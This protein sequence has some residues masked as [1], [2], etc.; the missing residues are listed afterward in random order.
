MVKYVKEDT[1]VV[2][3]EIPDE[4]TLAINISNC[5]NNCVGCHSPYL[6]KDIGDELTYDVIDEL[7]KE[8]DGVTC[9][10]FMGEGNDSDGLLSLARYVRDEKHLK[11]ALYSGRDVLNPNIF[12]NFDYVKT[13]PYMAEFGPL[14]KKTTNQ[15]LY[16]VERES[17]YSIEIKNITE[18]FWKNEN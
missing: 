5:Q 8:N 3:E 11:V 16:K 10:A 2:F 17:D 9:V 18:K 15:R 12:Y 13:G 1:S 6:R 4:I 14:N 7:L